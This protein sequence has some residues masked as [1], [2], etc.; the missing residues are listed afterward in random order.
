MY[1]KIWDIVVSKTINSSDYNKWTAKVMVDFIHEYTIQPHVSFY[2]TPFNYEEL[3]IQSIKISDLTTKVV[4][5]DIVYGYKKE[6][7]LLNSTPQLY[8]G[9]ID[10]K[11]MLHYRVQGPVKT[12]DENL[13]D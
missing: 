11:F 10:T 4:C 7:G 12:A 2:I 6:K 13:L 9:D 1:S 5:F 8:T 3:G